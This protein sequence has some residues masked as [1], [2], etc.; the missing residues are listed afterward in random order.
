[1]LEGQ[2]TFRYIKGRE[3][4]KR[5]IMSKKNPKVDDINHLLR[6]V[7]WD[8]KKLSDLY[9]D[10]DSDYDLDESEYKKH[11]EKIKGQLKR[12]S[13]TEKATANFIGYIS[14]IKNSEDF[15]K[16]SKEQNFEDFVSELLSFTTT[17]KP[18]EKKQKTS[19]TR[20]YQGSGSSS[21]SS[22][23]MA[24]VLETASKHAETISS[25]P[26]D[27]HVVKLTD[28]RITTEYLV[29]WSGDVG[30]AGGSGT[31]GPAY[32]LV[33]K[34]HWEHYHVVGPGRAF[35]G[36]LKIIKEVEFKDSILHI[37]GFTYGPTCHKINPSYKLQ[38]QF[39][40]VDNFRSSVDL[41]L[42][43]KIEIGYEYDFG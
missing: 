18:T 23:E 4:T 27:F 36:Y 10:N 35:Y 17:A 25:S 28:D 40:I 21:W 34:N 16:R 11:Y 39:R 38:L 22:K 12:A 5:K 13:T 29:F 24:D 42:V 26:S 32:C 15:S 1:M 43:N 33:E 9:L 7:G 14:F 6:F 3:G 2:V 31:W 20:Y 41:E 30:F 8:Q 37:T 19:D